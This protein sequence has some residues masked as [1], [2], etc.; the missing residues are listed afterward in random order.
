MIND[1]PSFSGGLG[2]TDEY[3]VS[4]AHEFAFFSTSGVTRFEMMTRVG[5]NIDDEI[6]FN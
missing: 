3:K 1:V 5:A 6:Y 4:V 2:L